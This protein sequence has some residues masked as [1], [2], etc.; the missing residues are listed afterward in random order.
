MTTHNY[1]PLFGRRLRVTQVAGDGTVTAAQ[2]FFVTE[3]FVSV[4]LQ[5]V[6]EDGAEII[7]RNANNQLCINEQLA[8]TF[9][10]LNVTVKF[11]GVNPLL[12]SWMSNAE[13][14]QDYALNDAG[15]TLSEGEING[16]FALELF[17]GLAGSLNDQNANGYALLPFVK[18]GTIADI[19]VNGEN[20]VDFTVQSMLS[21][22]GNQWGVGP[23]N[24]VMNDATPP[25]PAK[26]PT[27]LDPKT[28]FLLIDTAVAAP[29]VTTT[30]T[31]VP[32]A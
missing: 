29:A 8:S 5:A 2:K 16:T 1:A 9:K 13:A 11:C 31:A 3:G 12:L 10:R 26:L 14:Y 22:S 28:H 4:Q 19:E 6:T 7:L 20:A 18:S 32:G 24:V 23:Y 30:P 15:F 21:Q 17:T 25:V 27:A